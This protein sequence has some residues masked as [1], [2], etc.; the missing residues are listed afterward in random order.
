[1]ID[2]TRNAGRREEIDRNRKF[3]KSSDF[4]DVS[5]ESD[6]GKKMP[7][8][9]LCK[10]AKG[11]VIEL[12]ADFDDILI[13]DAYSELLDIRRSERVYDAKA[14]VTQNQ[15]AFIL[16]STQGIQKVVGRKYRTLRPVASAGARHSF[17]TYFI[18]RRVEGLAPGIYHYLP[19]EH[20]GEKRVAVEFWGDFPHPAE[21][22]T[23]MLADQR[24]T[25]AAPVA[26]FLSCVVY[27]A[28]WRYSTFAHRAALIDLGH[29]GQN[30]MLSASALGLGSCCI[31]AYDQALC[32]QTLGL[33]G[34]E[35]Y[36]VY[37]FTAGNHRQRKTG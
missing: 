29:V 22:L 1:M 28:E 36:T 32:D 23:K 8:P 10:S 6:Q 25:K 13:H 11:E 3:M 16:W 26:L 24:W 21:H 14:P 7:F 12:P 2:D 9:P 5:F 33:D 19:M 15:L 34:Q 18:A 27:R 30:L 4:D 20:V 37:A 31:A 17:E 35:E